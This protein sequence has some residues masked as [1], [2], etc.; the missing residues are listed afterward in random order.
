M[1]LKHKN[2]L[3][4][5]GAGFIPSHLVDQLVT[6]GAN[7]TVIDNLHAGKLNNLKHSLHKINFIQMD[8]RDYPKVQS[9]TQKQDVIFHLAANADVPF[10][11]HNPQYDFET[12]A[13]GGFNLLNSCL[14]T[15][16]QKIIFASSAAVYGNAIYTPVD[17]NHPLNP[18]S[19]YGASKLATEKLGLAYYKTYGLPFTAI[20]IFNTYGQ[21][22]PR[23]VMYDL[24]KKLYQNPHE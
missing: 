3:V 9:I 11:V 15:N 18:I 14:N 22:Q 20:R 4:T 23:Y 13:I 2:I 10:S 17:E 21:R 19:P 8:I 5:G 1:N 16:I 12:N 7:L 24:L 6:L